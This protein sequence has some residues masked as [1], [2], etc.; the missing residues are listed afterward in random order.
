MS[1]ESQHRYEDG[2][3]VRPATPDSARDGISRYHFVS[4][5]PEDCRAVL[6]A[7]GVDAQ[8]AKRTVAD[9]CPDLS[10]TD[11][12]EVSRAEERKV[13]DWGRPV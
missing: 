4:S 10:T 11:L 9:C 2:F 8:H 12:H 13:I 5:A 1:E 3:R 6:S 7:P